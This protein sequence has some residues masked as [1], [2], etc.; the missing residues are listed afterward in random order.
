M[1]NAFMDS[2]KGAGDPGYSPTSKNGSAPFQRHPLRF[3]PLFR[4][5]IWGGNRLGTRLNKTIHGYDRVAES[6]ELVDRPEAQSVVKGGSYDGWTFRAL[7]E[8]FPNECLG[9]QAS[10]NRFPL[11]LKYLDC[12]NVLSV[13]VHPDDAYAQ[14]MTPPD[15]GKT[16]A[17]YVVHAEPGSVVYAGL[18]PGVDQKSLAQALAAGQVLDC[19]H[20]FQPK[21]GDCLYITA[22]TVHALG[23]GLIVA[24]IQ[25]SSDTTFRLFDWNRTDA[26]GKS[27]PLHREPALDVTDYKRGPVAPQIP[28]PTA[29]PCCERLVVGDKFCLDRWRQD[30]FQA[31]E[32]CWAFLSHDRFHI[33]TVVQGKV[34]VFEELVARDKQPILELSIGDSVF[35]PAAC[36]S[37]YLR[38]SLDAVLLDAYLP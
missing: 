34:Q 37:L 20:V 28:Q 25:Q 26:T 21:V 12:H 7:L 18:K 30:P 29:E 3:H 19:L 6:W 38:G 17:W 5:Y 4:D 2:E 11:L 36:Q 22:G 9:K 10:S 27:R 16:E 31:S 15:L 33:W 24:E 35:V 23:A 14:R 1:V 32:N 8:T 13:Q